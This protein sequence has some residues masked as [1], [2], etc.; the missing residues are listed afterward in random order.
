MSNV[1]NIE[2]E[3]DNN[4]FHI[5]SRKIL[6]EPETPSMTKA[7]LKTGIVKNEKQAL[8]VLILLAVSMIGA[9]IFIFR[10]NNGNYE[11]YFTDP[12]GVRYEP[13]E[14]IEMVKNGYD[15]LNPNR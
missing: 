5:K 10:S 15:P 12:N 14:Y 1:E 7:L 11:V 4:E 8:I 9:A 6:G 3:E 13:A 2:F